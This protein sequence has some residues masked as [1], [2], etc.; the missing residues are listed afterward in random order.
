MY[1]PQA[2]LNAC[3]NLKQTLCVN[4]IYNLRKII[5]GA[6][7]GRGWHVKIMQMLPTL[8]SNQ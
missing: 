6:I 4:I 5:V 3:S 7:S 1:G 2:L 8:V